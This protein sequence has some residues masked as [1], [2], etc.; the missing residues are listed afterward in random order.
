VPAANIALSGSGSTRTLTINPVA[1]LFGAATIFVNVVGANNQ[2]LSDTFVL[3]VNPLL[4]H[5][6]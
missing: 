2:S 5:R 3:N 1:N 6:R 4:T